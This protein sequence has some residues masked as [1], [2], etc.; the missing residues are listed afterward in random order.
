VSIPCCTAFHERLEEKP[1]DFRGECGGLDGELSGEAGAETFAL[2]AEVQ[3][4]GVELIAQGG[5]LI[6]GF[7]Q[8]EAEQVAE[9]RQ[10][11][12]RAG[13]FLLQ[14]QADD[15][16]VR[17]EKEVG[18]QLRLEGQQLGLGESRFELRGEQLAGAKFRL[19]IVRAGGAENHPVDDKVDVE[20]VDDVPQQGIG[21]R[22]VGP[23]GLDGV[24]G[25]KLEDEEADA[26]ADPEGHMQ[27]D[28]GKK[29]LSLERM[30]TA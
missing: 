21:P 9:S 6:V 29:I 1:G 16:V 4:E 2:N 12:N 14:H 10:H 15:G 5:K 27:C 26:H 17:I 23:Q 28:A 20:L 24:I 25:Q 18:L 19:K 11:A 30:A 8:R 13:R 22:C 7:P 3:L